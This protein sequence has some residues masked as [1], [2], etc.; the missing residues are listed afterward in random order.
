MAE[1]AKPK[2]RHKPAQRKPAATAKAKSSRAT[3][4]DAPPDDTATGT[5]AT[6][7]SAEPAAADPVQ[8]AGDGEHVKITPPPAPAKSRGGARFIL[9][10]LI[11]IAA[12]TAYL[13]W[14]KWRPYVAAYLQENLSVQ[15]EDTPLEGLNARIDSLE[16][17]AATLTKRDAVIAKLEDER[18]R[19]SDSLAGVLTRIESLEHS[20]GAV[21]EMAKAAASAEEAAKA[22][23]SLQAL[24]ERL[25]RIEAGSNSASA[26]ATATAPADPELTARLARLE[27]DRTVASD[28]AARIAALE[29]ADENTRKARAETLT[30]LT[31]SASTLSAVQDR[32]AAVESLPASAGGKASAVV[33][34]LAQLRDAVHR[35]RPY[36][37]DFAAVQA[38]AG[39]DPGMK[40]ALSALEKHAEQGIPT[41]STMQAEFAGM[42]GTIAAAGG[43]TDDDSWLD[44]AMERVSSLVRFRR[45]DGGGDV[46][47]SETLVAAAEKHLAGGD[48]AGAVGAVEGLQGA[49]AALAAPWLTKAKARL[50][51]EQ[52]LAT[53][54]VHA[55]TLLSA[56]KE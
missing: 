47:S 39:D 27:Q 51:A 19:L 5:T 26:P 33:L 3:S 10:L 12:G 23:K 9:V 31:E 54:H 22:S 36:V 1:T 41:L 25:T 29:L 34:A 11:I 45:I 6:E 46:A 21:K 2:P 32:L 16:T 17:T 20:I 8:P 38:M 37:A 28:L 14:P 55:V 18:K 42:A 30:K 43:G 49:A 53:L 35:G 24:N 7:P 15:A 50:T 4:T 52:S 56:A 48:L 13:T 44:K 40:A